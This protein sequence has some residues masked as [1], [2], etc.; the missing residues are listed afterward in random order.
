MHSAEVYIDIRIR[1]QHFQMELNFDDKS[2][3][4]AQVHALKPD[5]SVKFSDETF[6]P[7]LNVQREYTLQLV[8]QTPSFGVDMHFWVRINDSKKPIAIHK[9]P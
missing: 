5:H 6:P 8:I 4:Q 3:I 1:I 2:S 9:P 7:F